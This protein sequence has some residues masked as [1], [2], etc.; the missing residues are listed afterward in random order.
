MQSGG[1]EGSA[2]WGNKAR[3][4]TFAVAYAIHLGCT[5][6]Q[7]AA[8]GDIGSLDCLRERMRGDN[9]PTFDQWVAISGVLGHI[10]DTPYPLTPVVDKTAEGIAMQPT[11]LVE[12][13]SFHRVPIIL[14]TNANEG[15]LFSFMNPF[16]GSDNDAF[17]SF[18]WH[19]GGPALTD[20]IKRVYGKYEGRTATSKL[21]GDA[22]FECP[23][24]NFASQVNIQNPGSVFFYRFS[25]DRLS[26]EGLIDKA[27]RGLGDI[28]FNSHGNK[29]DG[30]A[31]VLL[32]AVGVPHAYDLF[33]VFNTRLNPRSKVIDFG[34]TEQNIALTFQ[35]YWMSFAWNL[36][37]NNLA[38]FKEYGIEWPHFNNKNPWETKIQI[39]D[40]PTTKLSSIDDELL[41][42]CGMWLHKK[43][44]ALRTSKK[45]W[46]TEGEYT[47]TDVTG[48]D[49]SEGER[50]E[51]FYE[52]QWLVGTV[53]G[54]SWAWIVRLDRDRDGPFIYSNSVRRLTMFDP[55]RFDYD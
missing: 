25:P 17:A 45:P 16:E 31:G 49:V 8:T 44:V 40:P 32:N 51:I 47:P 29:L 23:T 27:V 2:I 41:P 26:A 35:F 12:A 4:E 19:Y 9:F 36:N 15:F 42:R 7:A 10:P 46:Q 28:F 39:R 34:L 24:R 11:E 14:G 3:S 13:G 54:Q 21:M 30:V 37:P 18:A 55:R 43:S 38:T 5:T 20:D 52:N 53:T 33:F 50:V 22:L 48:D 6:H 1:C